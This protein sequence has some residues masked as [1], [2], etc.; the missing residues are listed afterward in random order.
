MI[1]EWPSL[2]LVIFSF[3]REKKRVHRRNRWSN[4]NR[5][6]NWW[7]ESTRNYKMEDKLSYCMW[8]YSFDGYSNISRFYR[9]AFTWKQCAIRNRT[10]NAA[11]KVILIIG[12]FCRASLI[13]VPTLYMVR[14]RSWQVSKSE[15]Y[16]RIP[17][18][19]STIRNY[20]KAEFVFYNRLP[21]AGS[22]TLINVIQNMAKKHRFKGMVKNIL[23][24]K[25]VWRNSSKN[26]DLDH[27]C[28]LVW[29]KWWS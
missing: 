15:K 5:V 25:S 2:F 28:P 1:Y 11:W 19:N 14:D 9:N 29:I 13:P 4:L 27:G 21:K 8:I 3:S 12:H 6:R 7:Y 17:T 16:F 10:T 24:K 26:L 22:S 18:L 20:P 23:R